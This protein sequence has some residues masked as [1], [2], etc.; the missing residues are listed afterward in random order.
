MADENNKLTVHP[1]R[2]RRFGKKTVILLIAA[3]VFIYI[4]AATVSSLLGSLSTTTALTGVLTESFRADGYIFRQQNVI[5]APC[6]GHLECIVSD[7]DRVSEGQVIGYIYSEKPNP[8]TVDKIKALSHM[9]AQLG[10]DEGEVT[11]TS[12]SAASGSK[13]SSMIRDMSD[14]RSKRNLSSAADRKDELNRLLK[15]GNESS[16]KTLT[17]DEMQA[18]LDLLNRGA[19]LLQ[20]VKAETGGVFCPRTDGLEDALNSDRV[21]EL[22]PSYLSSLNDREPVITQSVEAGQPLCKII[23]N[24]SW[25]FAANVDS[26]QA[27][28]LKEGQSIRMEFFDL[29]DTPIKGTV[30]RIS[31]EEGGLATVVVSTNRY[32]KGIYSTNRINADIVTVSVEGIKLPISCLRVRDGVEGVFVIRLDRAK[33]VP[34]NV[35]YKNDKWAIVSP[36]ENTG[37]IKLQMYD[38]VIAD[39]KSVEEDKIVR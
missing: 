6:S 13:I 7:G 2:K 15:Q 28:G 35:R 24:Y 5:N 22:T 9:L 1:K 10:I 37:S 30:S 33:F 34:V 20:T 38:E 39:S 27:S 16:S 31:A 26:A 8:E 17:A 19:G 12:A 29:S 36:I 14:E 21:K 11:Y 25:Y 23:N 4:A 18:E 32:V 3:A